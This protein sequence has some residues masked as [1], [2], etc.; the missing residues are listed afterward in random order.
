[1]N[2][3]FNQYSNTSP[4]TVKTNTCQYLN[5]LRYQYHQYQ[6][7]QYFSTINNNTINTSIL[8]KAVN[9]NSQEVWYCDMPS[10]VKFATR[11]MFIDQ[12]LENTH[13]GTTL[14]L[15]KKIRWNRKR[16]EQK[17]KICSWLNGLLASIDR[18][19]MVTSE[20]AEILDSVSKSTRGHIDISLRLKSYSLVIESV[21]CDS[22]V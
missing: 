22:V 9:T 18:K 14:Q 2:I 21:Y 10:Y 7:H 3:W 19:V 6:C 4:N 15:K 5:V 20:S 16:F 17:R 11:F 8:I 1:M 12:D 13:Q